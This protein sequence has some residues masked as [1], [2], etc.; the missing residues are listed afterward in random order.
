MNKLRLRILKKL[1]QAQTPQPDQMPSVLPP[2]PTVPADLFSHL[3]EGYNG[4][5]VSVLIL[6]INQLNNALHYASGGK[7]K[8]QD[9]INNNIDLSSSTDYKNIGTVSQIIF[10]SFLN[11]KNSFNNKVSPSN[12]KSWADALT[13]NSDY[14][15]LSLIKSNSFLATKLQGN[16]K[17]IIQNYI[18]QIKQLNPIT[19]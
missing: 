15:N 9:I 7:G 6:L 13:M 1:S 18:N 12:I 4:S 17:T 14:N 3:A 19:T 10:N 5:T 8:F 2:P 11:K 16:L